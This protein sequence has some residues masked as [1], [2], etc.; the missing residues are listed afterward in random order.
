MRAVVQRVGSASVAVDGVVVG[1]IG[2]GLVVLLGV[3]RTDVQADAAA[4]ADKVVGLRVFPAGGSGF[5][6]SVADIGGGVLAVSQ[7]TLYGDLRK[8][9]R[10]SFT[11]AAP[12]EVAEPLYDGFVEELASLG[13]AVA[14]GAFGEMMEVSMVNEGP[15]T[16]L[17]ET[18]DGRVV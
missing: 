3:T 6:R 1:A 18:R 11:E 4:L 13:V 7:F 12:G 14:T 15:V 2:R 10:P 8:G 9:R 16:I 5:D 17:L